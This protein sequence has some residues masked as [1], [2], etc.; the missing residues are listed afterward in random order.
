MAA[1]FRLRPGAITL[2]FVLGNCMIAAALT[3]DTWMLATYV[4]MSVIAGMAGDVII[5]RLHPIPGRGAAFGLLGSVIA[6]VY[7][8]TYFV[9]TMLTGGIWWSWTLVV[10]AIVWATLCGL[11]LALLS[12]NG[13]NSVMTPSGPG[14]GAFTTPPRSL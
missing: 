11:A 12:A 14:N 13:N 2:L 3:N 4:A 8:G 9:V 1:R 5:A 10:G 6:G 7:Y